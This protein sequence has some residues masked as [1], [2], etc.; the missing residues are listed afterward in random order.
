MIIV[1]VNNTTDKIWQINETI[2]P[3]GPQFVIMSMISAGMTHINRS[4]EAIR[5]IFIVPKL[6]SH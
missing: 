2:L 3:L 1:M 5:A 4:H 6:K